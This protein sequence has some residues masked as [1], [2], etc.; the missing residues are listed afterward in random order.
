MHQMW[1][2]DAQEDIRN[3]LQ[4]QLC[5]KHGSLTCS[6]RKLRSISSKRAKALQLSSS[7]CCT[8]RCAVPVAANSQSMSSK[9][10]GT[11]CETIVARTTYDIGQHHTAMQTASTP[12]LCL[13]ACLPACP[14]V[15]QK[16]LTSLSSSQSGLPKGPA[17]ETMLATAHA[18]CP[19]CS[20]YT[21]CCYGTTARPS[22]HCGS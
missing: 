18:C 14:S 17:S 13:L 3:R 19:C 5:A 11:W 21:C 10:Q 12:S 4:S 20:I 15:R 16:R 22:C 9:L 6:S 2:W 7:N 8:L 1:R